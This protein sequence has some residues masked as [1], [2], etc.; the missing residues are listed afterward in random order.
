VFDF[1]AFHRLCRRIDAPLNAPNIEITLGNK[2]RWT[3][4]GCAANPAAAIDAAVTRTESDF[5]RHTSPFH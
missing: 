5:H 4:A 1:V 2:G 3:D